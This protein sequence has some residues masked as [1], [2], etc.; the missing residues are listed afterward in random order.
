M[1]S[2]NSDLINSSN[3]FASQNV[4]VLG[5]AILDSYLR[6]T[7]ERLCQEAPVPIVDIHETT[8]LPGGAANTAA[9]LSSLGAQV[10]FLSVIGD[11]E[12]G[13][14]LLQTLEQGHIAADHVVRTPNRNTLAKQRIFAGSQIV[15]RFDQGSIDPLDTETEAKL[16]KQLERLYESSEAIVISDYNHG[17]ITPRVLQALARLQRDD[18]RVMVVDSKQPKAYR[19]VEVTAVKLNYEEAIGLLGMAKVHGDEDR[20]EQIQQH[21]QKVLDLTQAQIAA[22]TLDR[23]G[24]LIFHRGDEA[25]YRTYAEPQPDSQAAG[26]GDTFVSALAL[27]LTAGAPME[28]AAEIASAAASIVVVKSGTSVC[29][30]EELKEF[31]STDEKVIHDVFQL[32]L[33]VALYRRTG[34]RIVFTNGCFD[35]LHRGHI[36]YLNRAKALGDILIVGL[37]SDRSVQNLKGP[38]RPINALEDRAQVL[39]ALSCVD[40]IVP[41]DSSTPHDLIRRIKP[42]VFVK[43]GDYTRETLP[44]ASLVDELGGRV[45]IL[46]YLESYS[47]TRVIEKIHHP[48][49]REELTGHR[50]NKSL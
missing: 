41:F 4:L 32:A 19:H 28:H 10:T 50:K 48:S 23:S 20:L 44:E 30:L 31:F 24:A 38:N 37:N 27:S 21:G 35:I 16:I 34:R 1:V 42:D 3:A 43:G 7:S 8:Y 45:E 33:R 2:R 36:T 18:P 5:E 9:N 6:G 12:P 13:S 29:S 49:A 22:I 14:R 46:P 17:L 40:H 26:A 47:T 39:A 25:P 15:V 11:D